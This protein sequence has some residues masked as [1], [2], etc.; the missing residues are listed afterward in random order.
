MS[1]AELL[2]VD[3]KLH[4]A[5]GS[6]IDGWPAMLLSLL[7]IG[8]AVYSFS[9]RPPGQF[10]A[11][12]VY[13][14]KLLITDVAR[15]GNRFA[16]VGEQGK[17]FYADDP[18]GPW[19]LATVTP[20]R[21]STLSRLVFLDAKTLVAVGHD[22]W[23]LRSTDAGRS[24]QE[25]RFDAEKSEPL[26]GVAGPFNG[27]L[28]AYGAFGQLQVSRDGG[29][30]WSRQELV[31]EESAAE[32]AVA[33]ASGSSDPF[34]DNYDPFGGFGGGGSFDDF[35]TRHLNGITQAS[36]GALWL[37]GERGLVARSVNGGETW[38]QFET[39]YTGSFYG[40]L[41]TAGGRILAYGMRGNIF[42]TRDAGESWQ[43][44]QSNTE[45]SM[46]GGMIQDNGDIVLAGG[47]NIII[48]SSNGGKSF[49][50]ISLKGSSSLTD[51]MVLAPDLWLTT[52]ERGVFLQGPD[53][54]KLAADSGE[55]Q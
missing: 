36:D 23:I 55:A 9:P 13:A 19:Q 31:K 35:A 46:Y 20:Q 22:S 52:G 54:P 48:R 8:A 40:V 30:S 6:W 27:Q 5:E 7:I 4:E 21:G 45:E 34:S 53:S 33:E 3:T 1:K 2:D 43:R 17:I 51:V 29:Q 44:S 32:P 15:R 10:P 47:N 49:Q 42:S 38:S 12:Q 50:V 26:L 39:G 41:E 18:A 24:W 25:I 14:D 37:V 28:W 16:A 11:T